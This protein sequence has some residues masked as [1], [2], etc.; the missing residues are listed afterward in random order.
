ME[1]I[2]LI[3]IA[4]TVLVWIIIVRCVLS[5]IRHD[6]YQP[7]IK[8]IYDVSEPVMAPFRKLVPPTAGIDFSPIFAVIALSILQKIIINVLISIL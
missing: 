5:F 8:F 1:I 3:N 6:P 4:F 7:L 2:A